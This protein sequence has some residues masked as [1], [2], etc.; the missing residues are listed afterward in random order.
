MKM[1]SYPSFDAYLADQEPRQ[2]A[3]IRALRVFVRRQAPHLEESVKWGNGCWLNGKVPVSYVYAGADH[4]QFGFF[5]GSSLKDP[6]GLLRG[7]GKFVRHVRLLKPSEVRPK[8]LRPLLAQ[9][10]GR[11]KR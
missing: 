6:Q 10:A 9:A 2:K 3:I 1:K 4:V 7:E 5:A 11:S 8:T